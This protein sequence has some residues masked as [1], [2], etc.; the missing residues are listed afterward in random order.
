MNKKLRI[1]P[2]LTFI[3]LVG[4]FFFFLYSFTQIDLNL[5]LSTS[6]LLYAIQQ[7]FQRIGY[8]QRPLSTFLYISIVLLL[9]TLYFILY[10]IAKKNRL[11]NKNLWTL[12]GI[13]A[14]LLFLSYPAFSYDL[15]NY[16]F[17]ARI[18]TLYQENPYI[19]KALDYP[20]DPW[21]LFMRWTHRT[22][23]YG[24]GWLAMTVPLSFIG[25]QKFV[26][27]LYLFKALMVGSYLASIVAIKRI[28]QVI[29]PS[30]TLAG[31]ILFALNPLVLTEALISGHNDIVMIAL[32][33]WSV[34][35]LIIKR[36]WWSIVLL[37]ISISIKFATVFLFPAFVNSFWHYKSREKINWEYVVL[38]SLAGMMVSVVAATFRTQFQPWYL[39]YIL[40]FASLLVHR[41]AVVISTIIISIAGSLQYI[42]FLYTGN[43]DPPIPTILNA[44]M[45]GGVLISLLVVVFQRRFIVK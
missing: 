40:P 17:D 38:I 28:M 1:I 8:F 15:F 3:Y 37:L 30:H 26:M 36:Y 24:P 16:L 33:L 35:F 23:P 27:T 20:Q 12:I 11:G 10:T 39:L 29:N 13:T 18:V 4:I 25:F 44:I 32:G 9:Y 21:I 45:V 34:Y 43:W 22:Y 2:L 6:H 31:I 42:P 7:F 19:H 14:G 41:P 5:T